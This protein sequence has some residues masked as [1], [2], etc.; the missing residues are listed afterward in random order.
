MVGVKQH[1]GVA[2]SFTQNEQSYLAL[3]IFLVQRVLGRFL[4]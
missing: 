3:K 1:V 4:L 2:S